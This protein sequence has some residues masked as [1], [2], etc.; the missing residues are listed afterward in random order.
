[1]RSKK[2]AF[3]HGIILA[4]LSAFALSGCGSDSDDTVANVLNKID[5]TK[6]NA[7]TSKTVPMSN[8]TDTAIVKVPETKPKP[9][10]TGIAVADAEALNVE[11]QSA[12][13]TND[14]LSLELDVS[15]A[16]NVGVTG[17]ISDDIGAITFGRLG[18]VSEV[19]DLTG[20]D[21]QREIWLNYFPKEAKKGTA[22]EVVGSYVKGSACSDCLIG[23][24]DGTYSLTLKNHP[25]DSK[26]LGYSFDESATNGIYLSVSAKGANKGAGLIA[27]SFFYWQ[28]KSDT[29]QARP[30]MLVKNSTCQSCHAPEGNFDLLRNHKD[31]SGRHSGKHFTV[32][33]CSFCH[34]DNSRDIGNTVFGPDMSIKAMAHKIHVTQQ[35]AACASCHK[36]DSDLTDANAWKAGKD[37]N[38]CQ[39][40]HQV[41]GGAANVPAIPTDHTSDGKLQPF[42]EN[43]AMCHSPTAGDDM[44]PHK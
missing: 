25:I 30:K 28:P 20:S 31:G 5:T 35:G 29:A 11:I 6:L 10:V 34:T 14:I 9:T 38:A 23:H 1:M 22:G 21:A 12:S 19:T 32:E 17:L 3:C 18:T 42:R 40:C 33:A 37:N 44:F 27:N 24:K 2:K 43:C 41:S 8:I 26:K 16:N 39:S 7:L 15:D 4:G 13:V 36:P